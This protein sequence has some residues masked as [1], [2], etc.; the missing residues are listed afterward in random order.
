MELHREHFPE[1]PMKSVIIGSF[2]KNWIS[3]KNRRDPVIQ[4]LLDLILTKSAMITSLTIHLA[5][6][7]YKTPRRMISHRSLSTTLRS[8]QACDSAHTT[9]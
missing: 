1:S 9:V 5:F 8:G 4:A 3:V 2:T 6:M 7:A